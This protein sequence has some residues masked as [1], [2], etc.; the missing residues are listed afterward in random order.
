MKASVNTVSGKATIYQDEQGVHLRVLETTGAI[1]EA[2][3]FPATSYEEVSK[4]WNSALTL[5]RDIINP[6]TENFGTRH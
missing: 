4:A 1:W 5:A 3:F 2:G 6:A